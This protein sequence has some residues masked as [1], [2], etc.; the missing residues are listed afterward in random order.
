[1][2]ASQLRHLPSR[3]HCCGN[4]RTLVV[5]SG[6]LAIGCGRG[7]AGGETTSMPLYVSPAEY[8]FSSTPGLLPRLV[9][10]PHAYFRFINREF[11][12]EVCQRYVYLGEHLPAVNLHGD[13]HLEQYAV[14]DSGRGLTDF[15]DSA[16]GPA[17]VDLI[18]LGTSIFIAAEANGWTDQR[19]MFLLVFYDGV[20]AGVTDPERRPPP[21]VIVS[22]I[23]AGFSTDKLSLLAGMDSLMDPE[24]VDSTRLEAGFDVYREAM[25]AQFPDL[26]E[27][28]FDGKR[29]GRLSAGVGSALDEKY[30]VRVE[31]PTDA[32]ED[33]LFLEI[34]EVRDL[35]G[36]QCLDRRAGDVFKILTGQS[37][38]AYQPYQYTGYIFLNPRRAR[39][40]ELG[41]DFWD[42]RT[43]WVHAWMDNYAELSVDTSFATPAELTEVL[44]DIGVQLGRGHPKDI[45]LPYEFQLRRALTEW[46]E[47]HA[48]ELGQAVEQM[49]EETMAAWRRFAHE[50]E[51]G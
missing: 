36:V 44:Y 31:G 25:F 48:A 14:T 11:T 22:R 32:Q 12:Q 45:A 34:K 46:L 26:P 37:R 7:E 17:V 19:D 30:L 21:P 39:E 51:G 40:S 49:Y 50:A 28:F 27:T 35:S 6:V 3:P 41:S 1:M 23:R 9:A 24:A 13:A 20:G 38:I 42:G 15:D 16:T 29:G 5:F 18:R 2:T 47:D 10:S 43:Y 4:W 8:D 33:D